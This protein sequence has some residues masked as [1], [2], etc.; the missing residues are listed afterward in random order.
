MAFCANCGNEISPQAVACPACGHPTGVRPIT[1]GELADFWT[2]F[3]GALLDGLI[4]TIPSVLM[5]FVIPFLG[6][7]A[8]DFLYHWLAVAYWDGQTI[9]KRV[10]GVRVVRPDG[11]P[12]DAGTA[13]ARA[14]MRI[15][16]GLAFAIG[17]LW[18]AWDPERRTWH[19]MVA[20]T[21]VFRVR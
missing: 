11:R 19:D 5:Y 14:A 13:A 16:S 3:A 9:G 10:V 12:V 2:R 21:R 15:V 7:I 4:L 8:V 1:T 20:D 6:G 18:A 17:F